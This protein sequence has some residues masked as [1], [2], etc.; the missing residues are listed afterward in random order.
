MV[1]L[2][3]YH[4]TQD[5]LMNNR[6]GVFCQV[7]SNLLCYSLSLVNAMLSI[8]SDSYMLLNWYMANE[9]HAAAHIWEFKTAAK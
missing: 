5:I 8:I 2:K 7:M 6:D 3:I 9:K 1:C 4:Y